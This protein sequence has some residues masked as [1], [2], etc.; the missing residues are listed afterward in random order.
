VQRC[1]QSSGGGKAR[2]LYRESGRGRGAL[3]PRVRAIGSACFKRKLCADPIT[4]TG[5]IAATS[6]AK[7]ERIQVT[8][9][10][11]RERI[12]V[13]FPAKRERIQVTFPAKRERIQVTFPAK[14]ER[15]QVTFPAKR[16]RIQVTFPAKRERIQV[17]FPA[18]REKILACLSVPDV[19]PFVSERA[20]HERRPDEVHRVTQ[21]N[22]H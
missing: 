21:A 19:D 13:T 3:A 22:P 5:R 1:A 12:Q 7:R 6:P 2:N 15:I 20:V 4:L 11:K 17:T 16:E 18:K 10:A 8:F 9:P 14:R